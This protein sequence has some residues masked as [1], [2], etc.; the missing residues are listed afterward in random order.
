MRR[1]VIVDPLLADEFGGLTTAVQA[2]G[3]FMLVN[4]ELLRAFA[5]QV[6]QAAG[7]IKAADVG[8]KASS[9]ADGLPGST[10]QWATRLVG[11]HLTQQ[12]NAIAKSIAD[13]GAAVRG[14]G[15]RYEVEDGTL[16]GR[17]DGLFG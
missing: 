2:K 9:A 4:P 6:D 15:D 16:A 8:H 14:A 5:A 7:G 17:F 11:E 12:A 1:G 13:M 3:A 10:T